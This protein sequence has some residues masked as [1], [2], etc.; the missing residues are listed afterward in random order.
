VLR[1]A[2]AVIPGLRKPRDLFFRVH[3]TDR[4]E[5]VVE[6]WYFFLPRLLVR[7]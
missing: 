5:E 1:E 6:E 2:P 3:V 7:M 4:E